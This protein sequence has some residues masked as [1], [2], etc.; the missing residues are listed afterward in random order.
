MSQSVGG[1]TAG[2]TSCTEVLALLSEFV[3]GELGGAS[4]E[5]VE[6]HLR[7]CAACAR[8]GSEFKALVSALRGNRARWAKLPEGLRERLRKAIQR[9]P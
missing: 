3:D 8:F 5:R 7:G 1:S 6:A 4:R 9:A 2:G